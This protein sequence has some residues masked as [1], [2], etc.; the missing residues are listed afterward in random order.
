V[1]TQLV[2]ERVDLRVQLLAHVAG[3]GAPQMPRHRTR[4]VGDEADAGCL[5]VDPGGGA[6]RG[7]LDDRG[8]RI[9]PLP[10]HLGAAGLLEQLEH[11]AHRPLH[12]DRVGVVGLE[13]RR[14]VEDALEGLE[15]V[16]IDAGHQDTVRRR[17]AKLLNV[18]TYVGHASGAASA[19]ADRQLLTEPTVRDLLTWVWCTPAVTRIGYVLSTSTVRTLCGLRSTS[20]VHKL[21]GRPICRICACVGSGPS[22]RDRGYEPLHGRTP[23]EQ[24]RSGGGAPATRAGPGCWIR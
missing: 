5:V 14:L 17:G 15:V 6:G 7:G 20:R 9:L 4:S 12:T 21:Q 22:V 16:W 10:P 19:A 13:R 11:V 18:C 2:V 8:V 3:L 23:A 24:L 1:R